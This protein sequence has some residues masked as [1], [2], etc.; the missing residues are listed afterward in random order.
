LLPA[1][2]AYILKHVAGPRCSE[3]IR[4]G[5]LPRVVNDFNYLAS[6][7]DPAGSRYR[8][9]SPDELRASSDA[10]TYA[11][12][13]WW[14]SARSK[15]VIGALQ[16]LNHGNRDLPGNSRFFTPE[17]RTSDEWN[18]HFVDALR[19]IEG[20][21]EIEEPTSEDW[22]GMVSEAYELLAELA[23]PGRQREAVMTRYL[24]FME[25]HYASMPP[26]LW[27]TQLKGQW[28]SKDTWVVEQ[29]ANSANPVISLYA[30]VNKR[31]TE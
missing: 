5:Q 6:A 1:L 12:H 9:I 15:Q 27:F 28:R 19:L 11:R 24:T 25:A 26:N 16:W 18:T 7:L 20:W 21:K 22:F 17:E 2:R 8:P 14:E 10:G 31:I 23:P 13:S 4:P 29:L 30:R 3:D